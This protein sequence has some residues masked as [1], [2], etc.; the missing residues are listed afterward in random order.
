MFRIFLRVGICKM[1][2]RYLGDVPEII[3]DARAIRDT[4]NVRYREILGEERYSRLR[5]M[6][7]RLLV[8]ECYFSSRKDLKERLHQEFPDKTCNKF[9]IAI[10]GDFKLDEEGRFPPGKIRTAPAFYIAPEAFQFSGGSKISDRQI[11]SY[12]HEF[13]HFIQY[14]LQ[15]VPLYLAQ[16][17]LLEKAGAEGKSVNLVDFM[18][19]IV[20]ED[21]NPADYIELTKRIATYSLA[22]L[23]KEAFEASNDIMDKRVLDSIGIKRE[24]EWRNVPKSFYPVPTPFGF[25]AVSGGGDHFL[26]LSDQQ[27]IDRV[28][29]WEDY[30]NLKTQVPYFHNLFD[31]LKTVKV[32]KR[33]INRFLEFMRRS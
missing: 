2:F 4:V 29:K 19:Q 26:G 25:I 12:I 10:D 20:S 16:Q 9:L 5:E 17:A 30:F 31:S 11:V 13:N 27:V 32:S 24:L 7:D 8:P 1:V 21:T 15:H 23:L 33:D 14:A 3:E 6:C 18:K 22:H 28:L